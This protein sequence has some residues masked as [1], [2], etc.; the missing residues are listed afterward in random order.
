M[1]K[2]QASLPPLDAYESPGP[3][4]ALCPA[5]DALVQARV[6][7][8]GGWQALAEGRSPALGGREEASACGVRL[9]KGDT[10]QHTLRVLSKGVRATYTLD[11]WD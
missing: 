1:P 7:R 11:R 10:F 2:P 4:F 6:W 3:A 9:Q 5:C 8:D